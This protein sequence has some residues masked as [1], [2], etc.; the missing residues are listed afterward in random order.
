MDRVVRVGFDVVDA[1]VVLRSRYTLG[2]LVR[3]NVTLDDFHKD[4][5]RGTM[6]TTT[7]EYGG[8]EMDLHLTLV[9][10]KCWVP[11]WK[12]FR[13]VGRH[14]PFSVFD[15]ALM[16]GLPAL[17]TRIEL[18][19]LEVST[20]MGRLVRE[21]MYE[22]E[23]EWLA[24]KVAS[25]PAKK[26]RYFRK[27]V[28][29]MASLAQEFNGEDQVG[30][31]LRLYSWLV[32]SGVLFP[33]SLYGANWHMLGYADAPETLGQYAWAEAVW[34]DV[35]ETMEDTQRKLYSGLL[36]KIQLNGSV[37]FYEY[38]TLFEV[39]N[40]QRYLRIASWGKIDHGSTSWPNR[41]LIVP[42]L[43][44]RSTEVR[45]DVVDDYM[46]TVEFFHYL[47]DGEVRCSKKKC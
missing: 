32:L 8:M 35:V 4:A 29:C 42:A 6:F 3:L 15:V 14:V 17:G 26:V 18:D 44:P 34:R 40:C 30:I 10:V 5:V 25:R 19:R 45:E 20:E 36:S 11:R 23:R 2:S 43:H 39:Q 21:R 37:W 9:L 12:A 1:D 16:T 33:W 13:L 24:E 31:F 22:W 28:N 41:G 46:T 38:T 7:L 47:E 27:Y